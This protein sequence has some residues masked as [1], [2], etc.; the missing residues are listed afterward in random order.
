M[1]AEKRSW[2][3]QVMLFLVR[4]PVTSA[5]AALCGC[6]TVSHRLVE[7][8]LASFA[9]VVAVVVVVVVVVGCLAP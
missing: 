5:A 6:P 8:R 3:T 4:R 1:H 9:V 7:P 2:L